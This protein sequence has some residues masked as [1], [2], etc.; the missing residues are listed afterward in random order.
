MG[1][2]P[3]DP[4]HQPRIPKRTRFPLQLGSPRGCRLGSARAPCALGLVRTALLCGAL[5]RYA[6]EDS[7]R[8]RGG[9]E[10]QIR[11]DDEIESLVRLEF[12]GVRREGIGSPGALGEPARPCL[13][14][15]PPRLRRSPLSRSHFEDATTLGYE[16]AIDFLESAMVA[17]RCSG[18][19]QLRHIVPV[20][21]AEL[22]VTFSKRIAAAELA[23]AQRAFQAWN[24]RTFHSW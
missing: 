12:V 21:D 13:R 4:D 17:A 6:R 18:L 10:D 7:H 1:D 19:G 16:K 11:K 23:H 15:N 2:N 24:I 9:R 5:F 3:C 14:R 20:S 22:L 8:S